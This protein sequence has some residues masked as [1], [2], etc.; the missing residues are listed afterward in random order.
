MGSYAL[1]VD[2]ANVLAPLEQPGADLLPGQ[3][4][5]GVGAVLMPVHPNALPHH[6]DAGLCPAPADEWKL[7][8]PARAF[9]MT[10]IDDLHDH[11]LQRHYVAL[12]I[13]FPSG[14]AQ[15]WASR[16]KEAPRKMSL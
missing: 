15:H 16:H 8:P 9:Y 1:E 3:C 11:S 14:S 5:V 7:L 12:I 6:F 13:S 4:L 10:A 2:A